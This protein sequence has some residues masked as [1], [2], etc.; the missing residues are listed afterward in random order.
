MF[1]DMNWK[2]VSAEF[3]GTFFLV[4]FGVTSFISMSGNDMLLEGT[5]TLGLTLFVLVHI[6]GPVS[7]CHLNPAITI[8]VFMS[9]K[10]K[11]DETI[12]YI[13]AQIIGA[14][15][16]FVMFKELNP[17]TA[18]SNIDILIVALIG[19]TFFVTSLLTSQDPGSIGATLFV[20]TITAFGDV[21]PG[22]S[23]GNMFAIAIDGNATWAFYGIIGS[24]MGCVLGYNVKENIIDN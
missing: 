17:E 24:L 22:V 4:F 20:V 23:L 8:P 3:L 10:M 5:I 12:A 1:K 2:P 16:G 14:T 11:Q 7:G 13:V 6:L 15:I 19:T 18:T 21:N 9:G